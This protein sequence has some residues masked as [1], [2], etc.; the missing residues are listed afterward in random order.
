MHTSTY[1]SPG[2]ERHKD[3]L[4]IVSMH[5]L[6]E[7]FPKFTL[8]KLDDCEEPYKVVPAFPTCANADIIVSGI[9]AV[10]CLVSFRVARDTIS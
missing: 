7:L 1:L 3:I 6:L 8:W 10:R 4:S 5:Q 2:Q 9:A